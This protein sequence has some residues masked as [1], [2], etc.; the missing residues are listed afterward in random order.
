MVRSKVKNK[1]SNHPLP[2][3]LFTIFV[4]LIG[5]GIII[6]IIPQ[7]LANPS[8]EFYILPQG[9]TVQQGYLLLGVLTAIFSIG[10][11][12]AAPILGQLSDRYGR[13]P[14]LAISLAGTAVS[15]LF[16][17]LG[18]YTANIPL[19]FFSRLVAGLT[20]GSVSVAQAAIADVS[21]PT[22]RAK[23]FGYMG[24]AFGL[25]FIL[26]P[27]IGGKLSDPSVVSWF[28]PTTPFIFAA[29]LSIA[30]IL[31]VLIFF[32]ETNKNINKKSVIRW[33]SSFLNIWHAATHKTL[34]ELFATN[35]L[36]NAGF[37]FFTT[38]FAVYLINKFHF[39]QGNIGDY[40]SYVGVWLFIAQ[41]V[42]V[43]FVTKRLNEIQT[44][45]ISLIGA[46]LVVFLFF[47]PSH[48]R[49]LLFITPFMTCFI[50]LTMANL[51]ALIS[52]SVEPGVQGEVLGINA[53]VQA[54]ATGI[55]PVLAGL[56]SGLNPNLPTWIAGIMMISS[57][58]FFWIFYKSKTIVHEHVE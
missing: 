55:P 41:T 51:T 38:F 42:V 3:I 29:L 34:R 14:V 48:W 36:F 58:V 22:N 56:I 37:T 24:A 49:G 12:L 19:L 6:P 20:G 10:Q 54:L 50:A 31:S 15:Y 45:R 52:R 32:P 9:A 16:F 28:N 43:G 53:S 11:F 40:F 44:L 13:K 8:S 2:V 25:G 27:Y 17:A 35:F 30:N 5:F 47:I 1:I 21:T 39:T 26:G 4:D 33:S 23:N 7:L 18:I 46:G 57:G